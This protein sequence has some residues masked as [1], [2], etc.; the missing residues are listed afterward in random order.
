MCGTA[1]IHHYTGRHRTD[2]GGI[3]ESLDS[4]AWARF[5]RLANEAQWRR[6]ALRRFGRYPTSHQDDPSTSGTD[7]DQ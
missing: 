1:R 3:S 7:T 5:A 2:L 6:E 4:E